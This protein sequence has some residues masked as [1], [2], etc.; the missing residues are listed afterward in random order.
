MDKPFSNPGHEVCRRLQWK[1]MFIEAETDPT[2]PRSDGEPYWCIET[3]VC[4]GPDGKM[5]GPVECHP[6][7]G[8]YD[9]D[10][11]VRFT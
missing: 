3:Q 2:V 7:R 9:P 4:F 11:I 10:T 6:R 1:S 8:C 5:V